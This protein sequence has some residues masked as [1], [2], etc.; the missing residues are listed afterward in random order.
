[1]LGLHLQKHLQKR[2][3]GESTKAPGFDA[4]TSLWRYGWWGVL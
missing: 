2:G 4:H 3:P 1:M